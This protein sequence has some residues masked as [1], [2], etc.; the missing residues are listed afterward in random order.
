[1]KIVLGNM[2]FRTLFPVRKGNSGYSF[3]RSQV[4]IT[5]GIKK[6]INAHSK[7]HQSCR[8]TSLKPSHKKMAAKYPTKL[9]TGKGK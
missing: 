4:K 6:T 1:M 2:I 5:W 7:L 8:D 3:V 9:D